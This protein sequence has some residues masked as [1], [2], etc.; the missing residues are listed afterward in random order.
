MT[1]VSSMQSPPACGIPPA[2]R[3]VCSSGGKVRIAW[4][5]IHVY[6]SLGVLRHTIRNLASVQVKSL[7]QSGMYT[8]GVYVLLSNGH[9]KEPVCAIHWLVPSHFSL[10][11][12]FVCQYKPLLLLNWEIN[13]E[14]GSRYIWMRKHWE[15]CWN[16]LFI[17]WDIFDTCIDYMYV[18][19]YWKS[20]IDITF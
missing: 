8:S 1:S 10:C 4:I 6:I 19:S 13:M 15:C 2:N 16:V 7:R 5:Y 3:Y 20:E 12:F 11:F 17:G 18:L 14:K 9:L